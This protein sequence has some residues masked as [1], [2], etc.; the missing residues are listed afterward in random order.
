MLILSLGLSTS[1]FLFFFFL[2]FF[3]L[4]K[5]PQGGS[6]KVFKKK[7]KKKKPG[8]MKNDKGDYTLKCLKQPIPKEV[9]STFVNL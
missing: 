3:F 5:K 6:K 4:K 2:C 9:S 1:F 7:A 8:E